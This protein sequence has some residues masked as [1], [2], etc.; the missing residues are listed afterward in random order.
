MY[1]G[2]ND[3]YLGDYG[4]DGL[5]VDFAQS[6]TTLTKDSSGG[7]SVSTPNGTV[8]FYDFEYLYFS[9]ASIALDFA[10]HSRTYI[11]PSGTQ[12]NVV[13]DNDGNTRF[14]YLGGND[15]YLGDYGIDGLFVDF[16]QSQT[17]LTKDSSG[18]YSVSTPNGT[19][20]F[21]DF[22]Y[23]Y[24]RDSY[25]PVFFDYDQSNNLVITAPG[26]GT[27]DG[28]PFTNTYSIDLGAGTDT[29]TLTSASGTNTG[30]TVTGGVGADTLNGNES[31]NILILAGE[32]E[33]TLD[34]LAFSG[35]ENVDLKAG[36]D[37]VFILP[38]G[39][40]TGLLNGGSGSR[41]VYLP[42]GG[43]PNTYVPG[44]G[45]GGGSGGGSGGGGIPQP[46]TGD[47]ITVPPAPPGF[48]VDGGY[49]AIYLNDNINS[50]TLT[51]PGSGVVDGTNFTNFYSVDL[52]GGNDSAEIQAGGSLPGL[53]DGGDGIDQLTLNSSGNTLVIDQSLIGTAAGTSIKSFESIDLSSGDDSAQITI[54]N[55]TGQS[56]VR[57]ALT[58]DGGAGNDSLVLKITPQEV[59]SLKSQGL[60]QSLKNYLLNPTGQ[61]LNIAISSIDLTLTGFEGGKFFN[62]EP[63]DI[64]ISRDR[65]DEN[66]P[67]A[68]AA[69]TFGSGDVDSGDT[70]TYELVG[71]VGDADNSRFTV[72]GNSLFFTSSPDY[73][74]KSSYAIRLRTTDLGGLTFEKS[75]IFGINN[76][77]EGDGTLSPITGNG[78]FN[79]GVTLTAGTVSG[80]PDGNGTIAGYQWYLNSVLLSG[81]GTTGS[82][83]A[84]GPQGTGTYKV[85]VTYTDGQGY[86]TTL[87]SADQFVSKI[88]NG[89]GNLSAITGSG[90]F[91]E[92]VTLTA[93]TVSGDLDGNGTPTAYQWYLNGST[94]GGATS[95]SYAVGPQGTGIYT[96]AVSYT[97]GQGYSTTLT[98]DDQVV[99][100]IDNGQGILSAITGNGLF[101]EGV[102]LTAGTVIGDP[103]GT[104]VNP[105]YSYQWYLNGSTIGG[106]NGSTYAVGPQGTGTYTVAVT[107]TDGQSYTTTLTSADQVVAKIDNGQGT[108]SAITGIGALNEGVTLTAG[109][110]FGD[111]DGNGTINTYQWFRNGSSISGANGATYLV[112]TGGAGTYTVQ[113]SYTDGQGYSTTLTSAGTVVAAPPPPQDTTA[114]TLSSISVQGTTVILQFSEAVIATS[115]P[116]TA[117][118]VA[119]VN[120]NNTATNRTIS[121]IALDQ[122][123]TSRVILTLTGTAPAS[124]VNLRVSYTDPAGNQTTGV[125]QDFAGNDLATFTNRF[126]DTFLTSS[127]TTLAS[128]YQN[129]T[130]TGTSNN[131]GT[132]NALANTIIGNSGAN[133]LSGL[134]GNDILIGG[135]GNDTL[136]GGTGADVLTGAG[137]T[138]TFRFALADSLLTSI[139]RI[140]DLVIGTDR[141]DGPSAVTAVNLRELG[142]V[143]AL[144]QT[145]IAAVLTSSTFTANR[146]AT[147]SFLDG[148]TS[149]TFLALNNGTAGFSST[150]DSII[151]ITGYSGALTNLAV[152]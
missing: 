98:S 110:V 5:F 125:V 29:A 34:G 141:I 78:A 82:T 106:A 111:L 57:K 70:F 6:Q 23:L 38:G 130:L 33:G 36:D 102:V 66:L 142:A 89:Q 85:A 93:G 117:F 107:Y 19:V 43:D 94:I 53:L 27:I 114:P 75:F 101:N 144:T 71:G 90:A 32:N 149:R 146:A 139:D 1:L 105:A 97:D 56:I 132:G 20:K 45:N 13:G 18:G 17:T 88:D 123:N 151:E 76:I 133:T 59:A 152:V 47:P 64:T 65:C 62:N 119:T 120:S 35:F 37:T 3:T 122:N 87:T 147:F 42:P 73:E 46:P 104:A 44:G 14:M 12:D 127:K 79:E 128:Q 51:G 86:S 100:K 95:S 126:A 74:T 50:I 41:I 9:D 26:A 134:A 40:L 143:S 108:L 16:T 25:V 137:G 49:N 10:N 28:I 22:E 24:F 124:N 136:I 92:G 91:T 11:D 113:V 84:V 2:G 131:S 69:A 103:D 138:D 54:D 63:Y 83:Y 121:T 116:L 8:K 4:I 145:G 30:M 21:Y 68:D 81:A 55:L 150:T 148:T 118:A 48:V 77:Q 39:S 72:S 58:L 15:T 109:S 60:Y 67:I 52:R 80:D 7:Y 112:P 129:L 99:A 96:V 140:T 115:V 61:T 31:N 135:D